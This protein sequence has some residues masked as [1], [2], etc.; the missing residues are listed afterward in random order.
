LSTICGEMLHIHVNIHKNMQVFA[1]DIHHCEKDILTHTNIKTIGEMLKF[2]RFAKNRNL[3]F[4]QKC[5]IFVIRKGKPRGFPFFTPKKWQKQPQSL[6]KQGPMLLKLPPM[7]FSR[8]PM[9]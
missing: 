6:L 5:C 9:S 7:L 4:A 2:W 8:S 1:P 3:D